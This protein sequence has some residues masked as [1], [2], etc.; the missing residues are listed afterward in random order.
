MKRFKKTLSR[1][2]FMKTG[3]FVST[4]AAGQNECSQKQD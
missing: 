1:R 4:A 2:D 3:A